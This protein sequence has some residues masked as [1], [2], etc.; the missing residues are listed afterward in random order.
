M[1]M[2]F[3]INPQYGVGNSSDEEQIVPHLPYP[4]V[5]TYL[6]EAMFPVTR[7]FYIVLHLQVVEYKHVG[8]HH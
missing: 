4:L 5:E 3:F 8:N 2:V 6:L 7:S 1:N